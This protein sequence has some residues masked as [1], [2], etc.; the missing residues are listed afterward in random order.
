MYEVIK[1]S[2]KYYAILHVI[3]H[4]I[5]G[6]ADTALESYRAPLDSGKIKKCLMMH[7]SDGR[8]LGTLEYQLNSLSQGNRSVAQYYQRVYSL[9]SLNL[10]KVACLELGED[11]MV[12]MTY[13]YRNRAL[14]TFERGLNGDLS[15]LLSV[16]EP[17]SLPEALQMCL[18]LDNMHFR[19]QYAHGIRPTIFGNS[20][21]DSGGCPKPPALPSRPQRRVFYPE[22]VH[23]P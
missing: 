9:L 14:D 4:K 5:T 19:W 22:L 15:R 23:F 2:P 20:N 18:K 16:S 21:N 11:A 3:R 10:D 6:D 17:K 1:G 12:A 13:S 7:Y 8:D